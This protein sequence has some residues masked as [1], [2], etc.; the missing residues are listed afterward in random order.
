MKTT[1]IGLGLI[2]GSIA[3]AL[4]KAGLAT[5]LIGVDMSSANAMKA[6]ELGL[7]DRILPTKRLLRPI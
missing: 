7:V 2:G 5:E 4:R 3:L 1:I 6:V